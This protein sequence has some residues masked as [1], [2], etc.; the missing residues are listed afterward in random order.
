MVGD[1]TLNTLVHAQPNPKAIPA[2]LQYYDPELQDAL[3]VEPYDA[4]RLQRARAKSKQLHAAY[5][6]Q[7]A[8]LAP[9]LSKRTYSLFSDPK[10][11]L[12]D[13]DLSIFSF[14][15]SLGYAAK[16]RRRRKLETSIKAVFCSFDEKTLN[17]LTYKGIESF[18]ANIPVERWYEMWRNRI[19]SLLADELTSADANLMQHA[20]LFASG[21]TISITFERVIWK[22]MR[23][24]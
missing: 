12:F 22:T 13:S 17:E 4:D 3:N 14:G 11:P 7:L 2:P 5:M 6:K 16:T 23:N 21:A 8:A 15:D 1:L 24:R 20:F 10:Q 18:N 9:R 19:D